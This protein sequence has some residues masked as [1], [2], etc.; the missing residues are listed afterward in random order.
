M[1]G[2]LP[3]FSIK[4]VDFVAEFAPGRKNIAAIEKRMAEMV[5]GDSCPSVIFIATCTLSARGRF[6]SDLGGIFDQF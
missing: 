4:L 2:I 1:S 3:A 6:T 5:P